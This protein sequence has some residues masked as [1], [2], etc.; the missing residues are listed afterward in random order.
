MEYYEY[1]TNGF[2]KY[3]RLPDSL[4]GYV[5]TLAASK[6]SSLF[7]SMGRNGL[8][9]IDKNGEFL[10]FKI[11][12]A[13]DNISFVEDYSELIFFDSNEKLWIAQYNYFIIYDLE[14]K[15]ISKL[16]L[17]KSSELKDENSTGNKFFNENSFWIETVFHF[18]G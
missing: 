6:D 15:S 8:F 7:L 1:N 5:A 9:K 2:I 11:P 12:T 10:K 16:Y 13:D 14:S 17:D 18:K 4:D 3:N